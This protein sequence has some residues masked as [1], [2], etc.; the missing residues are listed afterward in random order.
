VTLTGCALTFTPVGVSVPNVVGLDKAVAAANI[1]TAGLTPVDKGGQYS[2]TAP[3]N[4]V[5]SQDPVANTIVPPLSDVNYVWSLGQPVVP[6]V[7]NQTEAVAITMITGVDNLVAAH[8]LA[9]Q[10]SSTVPPGQVIV[11]NPSGNTPVNIGSTVQYGLS[12]GLPAPASITYPPSDANNGIYTVSWA[13]VTGATSYQLER[14]TN[15]TTW[16]TTLYNGANTTF[17]TDEPNLTTNYYRVKACNAA[18]GCSA[19]RTGTACAVSYCYGPTDANFANW[20][21]PNIHRPTCW[22]YP[23]QCHG[24]ADGKKT[25]TTATGFI[26]VGQPDMDI[27]SAGWLVKDPPKGT[28][29]ANLTVGG[30][31]VACGDFARNRT[32]TVSTGFIRISQPDLDKMSLY[33]G[34]KEPAKGPGTPANC[35]PGNRNP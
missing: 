20:M 4:E 19:Y 24:D 1:T 16:P 13:S 18:V 33:W 35:G 10:Y 5:I 32:G 7:L 28:G 8:T 25:G 2:N 9:D 15:G 14:S 29:I 21:D 26:Y 22:C 23:R 11:Q 12:L 3:L 34:V 27:M 30:V 17:K 31:P 6:D